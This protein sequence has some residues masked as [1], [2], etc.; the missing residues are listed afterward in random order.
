[1][2]K[3]KKKISKALKAID[4]E[5]IGSTVPLDIENIVT[6]HLDILAQQQAYRR[7]SSFPLLI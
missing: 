3:N 4:P 7:G 1:L 6:L 5:L 2:L